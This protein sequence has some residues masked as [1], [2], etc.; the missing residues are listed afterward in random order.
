MTG[1][2]QSASHLF[3]KPS[4]LSIT[5][6]VALRDFGD[7]LRSFDAETVRF[8]AQAINLRH[9]HF[10]NFYMGLPTN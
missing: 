8:A 10:L 2:S 4:G 1:W 6:I 7:I 3:V 9:V 5:D